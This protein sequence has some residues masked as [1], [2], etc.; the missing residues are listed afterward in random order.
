MASHD[1]QI[2]VSLTSIFGSKTRLV[3]GG[4]ALVVG[5]MNEARKVNTR[6]VGSLLI[7][8]STQLPRRSG[9]SVLVF[10]STSTGLRGDAELLRK[11]F[12]GVGSALKSI[13]KSAFPFKL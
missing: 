13:S 7:T 5:S 12:V 3:P 4:G 6:L 9:S 11:W 1:R 2:S 10:T 8:A